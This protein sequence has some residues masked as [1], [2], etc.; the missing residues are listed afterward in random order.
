MSA[1]ETRP[2]WS[3][4]PSQE[5]AKKA[6]ADQLRQGARACLLEKRKEPS[7]WLFSSERMAAARALVDLDAMD[8]DSLLAL[9]RDSTP[10]PPAAA[11]GSRAGGGADTP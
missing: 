1:T 7:L 2:Q 6:R 11:G 9:S 3:E 5:E 10:A 4:L 8:T